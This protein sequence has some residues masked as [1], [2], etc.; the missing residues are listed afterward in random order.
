MSPEQLAE[1]TQR[2]LQK[3]PAVAR[4]IDLSAPEEARRHE[5]SEEEV[6]SVYLQKAIEQQART[7]NLDAYR[8][9]VRLG[10]DSPD[11]RQALLDQYDQ[12][13][14][15]ELGMTLDDYRQPVSAGASASEMRTRVDDAEYAQ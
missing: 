2:F 11:E 15:R 9:L 7:Y 8:F 12:D 6:R 14:A 13:A 1:A 5:V 10:I 3:Y 4:K